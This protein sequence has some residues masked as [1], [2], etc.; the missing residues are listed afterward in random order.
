MTEREEWLVVPHAPGYEVSSHRR[1][2]NSQTGRILTVTATGHVYVGFPG[3][4][5]AWQPKALW[6]I[7]SNEKQGDTLS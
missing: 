5:S 4:R 2:R 1:V 6:Q 7:A 3:R